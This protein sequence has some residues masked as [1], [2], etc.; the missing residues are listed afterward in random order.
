MQSPDD[1]EQ[2]LAGLRDKRGYLLPHHGLMALT[3]PKLLEAYDAAYTALALDDRILSHHDR[4]FVWLAILIATDEAIATHHIP[5]FR[6]AGGTDAEIKAILSVTAFLC[7]FR[8]YGF[9]ERHWATHLPEIN[10]EASWDSA[11]HRAGQG[12]DMRLVHLAGLA[13]Q[14]CNGEWDGLAWQLRAA[15]RDDVPEFEMAEALSL[16]MF[17]GSVPYFVEAARVWRELIVS[18]SVEA[19]ASFKAWANFAGQEGHG[20]GPSGRSGG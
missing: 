13:V 1:L 8:A 6:A 10:V 3:A 2:Q 15:Y 18:G 12:A 14:T 9:T 5:K 7:G 17:P 4:E 20:G 11:L 16:T 19:S